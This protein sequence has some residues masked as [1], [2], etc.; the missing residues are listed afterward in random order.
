[1]PHLNNSLTGIFG[2]RGSGKTYLAAEQF[3]KE[4]RA[5]CWNSAN[6]IEFTARSTH[7]FQGGI[8]CGKQ[9]WEIVK[10]SDATFRINFHP[11]D[12]QYNDARTRLQAPSLEEISSICM[13]ARNLTFYFDEAHKL[14]G[15]GYAPPHFLSILQ[16][17]RPKEVS[18]VLIAHRMARIPKDFTQD[19]VDNYYL[20]QTA[21]NVDLEDI[22]E[23]CGERVAH[24][25]AHLR[26]LNLT[27]E[28]PIPGQYYHLNTVTRIGEVVD[29]GTK[30]VIFVDD[31][32]E[33]QKGLW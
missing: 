7:Q 16:E 4:K 20:F 2:P 18:L 11:T 10:R 6:D 17:G 33:V 24:R 1:M 25:V 27:K 15:A 28:K 23:R 13:D 30:K 9:I 3:G 31:L 26:R 5:I 12:F 21:E 32:G 19:A 8:E 22:E 14:L 29:A